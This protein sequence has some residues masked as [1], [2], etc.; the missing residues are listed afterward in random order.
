MIKNGTQR[1]RMQITP[2][3]N[4]ILFN[5]EQYFV[6][7]LISICQ[8]IFIIFF[9]SAVFLGFAIE[10]SAQSP[11]Y[12]HYGM[13]N[14]LPSNL[15]YCGYEDKR[16]VM[17]FGTDKGLVRF[18]NNKF[19]IYTT[20]DGLPDPEV[21]NIWEDNEDRLWISCF[22]K[23]ICFLKHGKFHTGIND[24]TLKLINLPFGIS[25]FYG[26]DKNSIWV[27]AASND[28]FE[29][30]TNYTKKISLPTTIVHIEQ[31]DSVLFAFGSG[32][33]YNLSSPYKQEMLNLLTH[34]GG[35]V[36][37]NGVVINKNYVL[38]SFDTRILLIEWRGGFFRVIENSL[39]YNGRVFADKKNRFWA[40][41][42]AMGSVCFDNQNF[43][44][45]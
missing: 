9:R 27:G 40:C 30:N 28:V 43:N 20:E 7:K 44:L 3:N 25:D 42:P 5:I 34:L 29:F 33:I 1:I 35:L 14:G 15:I 22:R 36:R 39:L 45:F 2:K 10:I 12:I 23:Q 31:I 38:Y 37:Y 6:G 18:D 19:K 8:P 11:A 41:S 16:G 4:Y 32:Y 26:D 13:I 17:W 21:F 24:S